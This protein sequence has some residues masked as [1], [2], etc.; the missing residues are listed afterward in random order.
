MADRDV[1][2]DEK[3]TKRDEEMIAGDE[4]GND[5]VEIAC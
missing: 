2:S 3:D 1:K 4:D 5:E